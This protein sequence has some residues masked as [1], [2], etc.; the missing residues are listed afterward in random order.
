MRTNSKFDLVVLLAFFVTSQCLDGQ[1]SDF[2]P[3]PKDAIILGDELAESS[4]AVELL[5]EYD[6]YLSACDF[7]GEEEILT[8]VLTVRGCSDTQQRKPAR[9]DNK[10]NPIG[11]P[12]FTDV[13]VTSNDSQIQIEPDQVELKITVETKGSNSLGPF[14][15]SPYFRPYVGVNLGE[16]SGK[17]TTPVQFETPPRVLSA[18][19]DFFDQDG[20]SIVGT[21][22]IEI[23]VADYFQNVNGQF[24]N[25]RLNILFLTINGQP[26][27][28][29][30]IFKMVLTV[31]YEGEIQNIKF[32]DI[33]LDGKVDLFDVMPFLELV[34]FS[35][36]Q[37]EGDFNLD[38]YVNIEDVSEFVDS[39]INGNCR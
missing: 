7:I 13:L 4:N 3:F 22:P 27:Q 36:Y 8:C 26:I 19:I 20:I 15:G 30:S 28:A 16:S 2:I 14:P 29:G 33:N 9:T 34:L 23:P 37:I 21:A 39:I 12:L 31:V 6:I 25:G 38:G 10:P 35:E 5:S 17:P 1:D 24:W 11:R 32:G 18:N